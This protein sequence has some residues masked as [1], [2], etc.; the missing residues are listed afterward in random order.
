MESTCIHSA[1]PPLF[2]GEHRPQTT[3]YVVTQAL[4]LERDARQWLTKLWKMR[5]AICP[6]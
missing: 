6:A 5:L 3:D 2:L 1:V 4:W